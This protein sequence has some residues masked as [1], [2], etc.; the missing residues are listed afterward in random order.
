[1]GPTMIVVR[2]VLADENASLACFTVVVFL[3]RLRAS[4]SV[5]NEGRASLRLF[6]RNVVSIVENHEGY[7]E[8]V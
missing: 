2:T 8:T 7:E 1:M 4:I 6:C 3:A 5:F